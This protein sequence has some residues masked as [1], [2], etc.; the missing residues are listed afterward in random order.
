MTAFPR[1]APLPR[2][3]HEKHAD[4][5]TYEAAPSGSKK[6]RAPPLAAAHDT[7]S[8]ISRLFFCWVNPV[9][10]RCLD[11][12]IRAELLPPLSTAD[13]TELKRGALDD[14]LCREETKARHPSIFRATLRHFWPALLTATLWSV[15]RELLSFA[16][17]FL[18]KDL[19]ADDEKG[20]PR[21]WQRGLIVAG[22]LSGVQLLLV[23]LDSHLDFYSCRIMIRVET[24]LLTSLYKRIL[25]TG[26]GEDVPSICI[27]RPSSRLSSS[28]LNTTHSRLSEKGEEASD[29]QRMEGE[30][31]HKG[32]LFN[33]IFV[34]IPSAAEMVLTALD[35]IIMPLRISLAVILLVVQVGAACVPGVLTLFLIIVCTVSLTAYNAT[36]KIPFMR[37]RDA[38]LERSHE[39]LKEMRTVR[40][41]GWE[42]IAEDLV[43]KRREKEMGWISFR[44]F[45][46]GA[47]SMRPD[48]VIPVIHMM[49][50]FV[51]PLTDL[52]YS[53]STVI[54]GQI[55]LKRLQR[56]FFRAQQAAIRDA[57]EKA[58]GRGSQEKEAESQPLLS[59]KG[60]GGEGE[61]PE[62]Q[63]EA[64]SRKNELLGT[65]T[66]IAEAIRDPELKVRF[67]DASFCWKS[68][69]CAYPG[70]SVK[71]EKNGGSVVISRERVD[72]G[73]AALN[74]ITLDVK[75]GQVVLITGPPG[76]GKTTLLQ[77]ILQQD[78]LA[79]TSGAQYIYRGCKMRELNAENILEGLNGAKSK[80]LSARAPIGY[81]P[82]D[83]W[84]CG[85]TIRENIIFGNVFN[86]PLYNKVVKAC[87]LSKDFASWR[88]GDLRVIDEGGLDLSGGQRVRVNIAR[89][90]YG[91]KMHQMRM[92]AEREEGEKE[93]ERHQQHLLT[94]LVKAVAAEDRSSGEV[95]DELKKG[96]LC[97][98]EKIKQKSSFSCLLCFDECFNN[99]DLSVAGHVFHNL[100]GP[101]GLLTDCA[102]VLCLNKSSLLGLLHQH[103]G[104]EGFHTHRKE[105]TP[106]EGGDGNS[107]EAGASTRMQF[108][109]CTLAEGS[110]TWRGGIN[111]FIG[112]NEGFRP[113][114]EAG[115]SAATI[116]NLLAVNAPCKEEDEFPGSEKGESKV[117]GLPPSGSSVDMRTLAVAE[118][119]A[120]GRV[121]AA[122]Y[123]WKAS[124]QRASAIGDSSASSPAANLVFELLE[125]TVGVVGSVRAARSLHQHL[126]AGVC[127]APL[128]F[129]DQNPL[130]RILN[131]FAT[132]V[133]IVD[134][135]ILRRIGYAFVAA[136]SFVLSR[137]DPPSGFVSKDKAN[138][139]GVS[140][141]FK[142]IPFAGALTTRS[143]EHKDALHIRLMIAVST[144]SSWSSIRIELM[145]F[146]LVIFNSTLPGFLSYE[147]NSHSP[148]QDLASNDQSNIG[149][150]GLA[151]SYSISIAGALR[152]FLSNVTNMEKEMCSVERIQ[153]PHPLMS[154]V[155]RGRGGSEVQSSVLPF[156]RTGLLIQKVEVRYRAIN[157]EEASALKP[158][159]ELADMPRL[160]AQQQ[161]R[162][163][164]EDEKADDIEANQV[165][166][167]QNDREQAFFLKPSIRDLSA[168][169][170]PGEHIG[171]VGRTG[172]DGIRIDCLPRQVLRNVVGFLPQRSIV[173]EGWTVRDVL[174]PR[175]QHDDLTLWEALRVVGLD[176]AIASL[177][178]G[179]ELD[180]VL[181]GEGSE[182]E[183][184]KGKRGRISAKSFFKQNAHPLSAQQLRYLALGR[185]VADAPKLRLVLIDEPPAEEI[186]NQA[187][188]KDGGDEDS[189]VPTAGAAEIPPLARARSITDIIAAH[190][191]QASVIVVAHHLSSLRG[192]DRV[193]VLADGR[194]VGECNPTEI[195]T[196]Q[197][198]NSFVAACTEQPQ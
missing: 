94:C 170:K 67:L 169:V 1:D 54:E 126:W 101:S 113:S 190:F 58:A 180:T 166:A 70:A 6:P 48:L 18:L 157:S 53:I 99:L 172:A 128:W 32:A 156:K 148:G 43:N 159:A 127:N 60:N 97:E 176:T 71:A 15:F 130:G 118:H 116:E 40:L 46:A 31:A 195:D 102:V 155:A 165:E 83:P 77:S 92:N 79:L 28:P 179:A 186:W 51:G 34:D 9:T 16:S 107:P 45:L 191:Q 95:L 52:P 153:H 146:P 26:S 114:G 90:A 188:F 61:M 123:F 21:A 125:K 64:E 4:V 75:C 152:R 105:R 87:E 108:T 5:E 78:S 163:S 140:E 184:R 143:L 73:N 44:M 175:R 82:Q 69:T 132:D 65:A 124:G 88:N 84:L 47:P 196:E 173:F 66:A 141:V 20:G 25:S 122:S 38:R 39:C 37:T 106:Q 11:S 120:T 22:G 57:S 89:A 149:L 81:V 68:S 24:A 49:D 144:I 162:Q 194:K 135:G 27:R 80:D 7:V 121:Q 3:G 19:L 136:V 72:G 160:S 17:T 189:G 174:D 129:Y 198:F 138:A 29:R 100:F 137:Y 85:G 12:S 133:S 103:A 183:K 150:I 178:G 56:Y 111:D 182:Q 62:E 112:I 185:L 93:E 147:G 96:I 117:D 177:P 36:L 33:V 187:S 10:S 23:F 145:L 168:E 181:V 154:G 2:G 41:L 42:D 91:C 13:E 167:L 14:L 74:H 50:V 164:A 197:K 59:E 30:P 192:C 161:E 119:G 115:T 8:W 110:I 98:P 193:W 86:L 76:S 151:I 142:K 55:S 35:L 104:Q 171:I 158:P 63:A 139:M 109:I 134:G 131:R